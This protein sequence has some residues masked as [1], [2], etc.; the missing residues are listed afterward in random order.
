MGH[1]GWFRQSLPGV[2]FVDRR[3]APDVVL[4]SVFGNLHQHV[5]VQPMVSVRPKLVFF[6]GENVRPPIGRA[7]LCLSFDHIPSAPSSHV[8]LP[9]WIFNEAVHTV[10]RM[11]E[12]RLMHH[13]I[14]KA[15]QQRGFCSWVASN[16]SMYN[17]QIRLR[18][19]QRLS[20]TYRE[21][22][23]GGKVLNNVGGPVPDKMV[24][25][26]KYKFNLDL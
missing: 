13:S 17:A 20:T 12:A 7:P 3:E 19:V 11:H 22:A 1:R 24:F 4:F 10:V 18:F 5:A 6:T 9:L 23:C 2:E 8:R 26:Q 25:L 16:A 21:V 15:V 14:D